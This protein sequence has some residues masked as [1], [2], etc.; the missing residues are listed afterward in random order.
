[1]QEELRGM[2][3]QGQWDVSCNDMLPFWLTLWLLFHCRECG[4]KVV[5]ANRGCTICT[6]PAFVDDLQGNVNLVSWDGEGTI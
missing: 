3:G 2:A 6:N 1:M 5:N 4:I